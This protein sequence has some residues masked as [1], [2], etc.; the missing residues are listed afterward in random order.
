MGK[1]T[2]RQLKFIEFYTDEENPNTYC[3]MRESMTAAG[4]AM[5]YSF[6]RLLESP[7]LRNALTDAALSVLITEGVSASNKVRSIM[8]GEVELGATN[9]LKAAELVLDRIG[10]TKVTQVEV[11][12]EAP[13][14]LVVVPQ[15]LTG[16]D[17]K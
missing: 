6:T 2:E 9:S 4:F 5:N 13:T 17:E 11:K 8:K 16:I 12:S 10:V 1:L 15:K 7:D 3:K 14:A